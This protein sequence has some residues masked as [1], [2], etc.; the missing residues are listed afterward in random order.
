MDKVQDWYDNCYDEW[1]RL[2]RH[3]IEFDIT[4]KYMDEY[5]EGK[6]LNIFDIGGGPGRYSFYLADKGHHVSLL[7]ISSKNIKTAKEKSAEAGVKLA[8]YIHADAKD[9]SLYGKDFDVILLMGPLYHIV[10]EDERMNALKQAIIHLKPGGIIFASFISKYAPIQDYLKGLH[11]IDDTEQI[12]RYLKDGAN[13]PENGFTTAYFWS[14]C[15]ARKFMAAA[16]LKELAF[17][18]V[19]NILCSKE[20]EVN[21]LEEEEYKKWLDICYKLGQDSNLFGSSEHFLYVGRKCI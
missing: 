19:E 11:H 20:N 6:G 13:S 21:A 17:V 3:R 5:I 15:E 10:S 14:P 12:I 2:S 4:K 16:G 8:A 7:D 9:L 1:E 18:G